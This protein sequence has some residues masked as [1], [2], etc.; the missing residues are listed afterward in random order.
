MLGDG[1]EDITEVNWFS[2][3]L[4]HRVM[5]DEIAPTLNWCHLSHSDTMRVRANTNPHSDR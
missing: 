4:T 5:K 3:V 2:L 1:V